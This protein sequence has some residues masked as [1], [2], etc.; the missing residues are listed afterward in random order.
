M[1][2]SSPIPTQR[3]AVCRGALRSIALALATWLSGPATHGMPPPAGTVAPLPREANTLDALSNKSGTPAVPA[4]FNLSPAIGVNGSVV[5]ISGTNFSA[6]PGMNL[7]RFGAVQANVLAAG[8][9]SLIV[10]VPASATYGPVT[11][12]VGGL[13]AWSGQC[14][15]PTFS[16][17]NSVI[18]DSSFDPSFDLDTAAGPG[19]CIIADIDGDGKPDLIVACGGGSVLSI[20]LNLSTPGTP[21]STA[22][23]AP[24][25]DLSF[26]TNGTGGNPY[27]VRAV[28]LDGDGKLDLVATEV[29]GNRVSV[30]HNLSTPGNLVFE[31]PFALIVGNDCRSAAAGDLDGDGRPDI[32]AL[33]YGDKTISL[34]K[35]I[36]TAAGVLNASSFAAPVVLA[37]PGGPY[38]AVIADLNGDGL[39]DLAVAESDGGTVTIFQNAGGVLSSNTFPASF[40]LPCGDTT[41]SLVA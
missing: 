12:T 26:P 3:L 38:E 24:P 28:D 41:A 5:T 27:R 1:N 7:V 21:L 16:G 15:E 37:A 4:I 31:A 25:F 9:A 23:F 30:F 11:V 35:N 2:N 10:T 36:G 34:L 18:S 22:S 33:N 29:G 14:F 8:P 13:T 19:T 40:D 39:P 17:T 6:T 20:Y 32:V